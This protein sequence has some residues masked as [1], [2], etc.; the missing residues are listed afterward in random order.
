[1]RNRLSPPYRNV[2]RVVSP[3]PSCP[4]SSA[5]RKRTWHTLLARSPSIAPKLR[6][7]LN[8]ALSPS[9]YEPAHA[10]LRQLCWAEDAY[11]NS[12]LQHMEMKF[13]E[14][15]KGGATLSRYRRQEKVCTLTP[16]FWHADP[17]TMPDIL[18]T[19][20]PLLSPTYR[21]RRMYTCADD[22]LSTWYQ[23]SSGQ[24]YLISSCH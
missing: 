3:M 19:I 24:A 5:R 4:V 7:F 6:N 23:I 16:K 14:R 21:G 12:G 8:H 13:G 22:S 2:S 1:M 10:R 9:W 17:T 15:G 11:S 18:L 20:L